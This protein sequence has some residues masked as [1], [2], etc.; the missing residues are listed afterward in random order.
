MQHTATKLER[1]RNAIERIAHAIDP[2][3][4]PPLK[5]STVVDEALRLIELGKAAPKPIPT[6]PT[7]SPRLDW[8]PWRFEKCNLKGVS[9][10]FPR[11]IALN[12][13]QRFDY[14]DRK[15]CVLGYVGRRPK[16]SVIAVPAHL[17]EDPTYK[18]E[19]SDIWF[20]PTKN[21]VMQVHGNTLSLRKMSF[22]QYRGRYD[23]WPTAMTIPFTMN[24]CGAKR[25]ITVDDINPR[26]KWPITVTWVDSIS[27]RRQTRC[28]IWK[29]G[30]FKKSG[31]DLVRDG[32][33]KRATAM[34]WREI[35]LSK[36]MAPGGRLCLADKKAFE[37]E[38]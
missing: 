26:S 11:Y 7:P 30:T 31:W 28:V 14:K 25:K 17:I 20:F 32:L 2:D 34:Y 18:F 10:E 22:E 24:I 12:Q 15:M 27:K 13:G 35:A 6:P 23:L 38:F 19:R 5:L 16:F 8:S 9:P 36:Q 3:S 37:C 1:Y 21:V 33:K 29:V 4:D